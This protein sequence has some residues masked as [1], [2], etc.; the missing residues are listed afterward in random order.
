M[1]EDSIFTITCKQRVEFRNYLRFPNKTLDL[2]IVD[3]GFFLKAS[4]DTFDTPSMPRRQRHL[5]LICL[6]LIQSD[7]PSTISKL[8]TLIIKLLQVIVRKIKIQ[9]LTTRSVDLIY[10]ETCFIFEI[11]MIDMKSIILD[12]LSLKP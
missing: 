12:T 8:T 5:R 4:L 7:F 6:I 9:N 10:N 11:V 2:F 1:N 3:V